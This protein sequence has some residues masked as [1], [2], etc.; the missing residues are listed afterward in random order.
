MLLFQEKSSRLKLIS[1][2]S[3]AASPKCSAHDTRTVI[4]S[5]SHK[6]DPRPKCLAS[7]KKSKTRRASKLVGKNK[8]TVLPVRGILKSQTKVLP[9]EKSTSCISQDV[10]KV[11]Q[12]NRQHGNKHVTFS[13]N[14]HVLG[15]KRN[16]NST[17]DSEFQSFYNLISDV[18]GAPEGNIHT[19]EKGESLTIHQMEEAEEE[20]EINVQP[21]TGMLSSTRCNAD[22]GPNIVMHH[23]SGEENLFSKSPALR[24][25]TMHREN[26]Q[27]FEGC[28][29]GK[30]HD[31]LYTCSVAP[32][33]LEDGMP[34]LTSPL[35]GH[36][37]DASSSYG[38]FLAS[39]YFTDFLKSYPQSPNS[40]ASIFN[41]SANCR[42]QFPSQISRENNN[43]RPLQYQWFPHLSPKELMR[44]ICSLPDWNSKMAI[45]GETS[46]SDDPIGLPLNSQGELIRLSSSVN[47]GFEQLRDT[48]T[49]LSPSIS[50]AMH[51]NVNMMV[52]QA[53]SRTWNGVPADQLRM[54]S[55]GDLGRKMENLPLPSRLDTMEQYYGTRRT[56]ILKTGFDPSPRALGSDMDLREMLYNRSRQDQLVQKHPGHPNHISLRFSQST[57]RLMGQEFKIGGNELQELESREVW[58][59]KQTTKEQHANTA[60]M[61]SCYRSL[62]HLP[63][64]TVHP[65]STKLS[66]TVFHLSEPEVNP[67]AG[68][69]SQMIVPES[70]MF[71]QFLQSQDNIVC[72]DGYGIGKS[73]MM[74]VSYPHFSLAGTPL[75]G[76]GKTICREPFLCGYK[77]PSAFQT[78]VPASLFQD[79][80]QKMKRSYIE[81]ENKPPHHSNLAFKYPFL[82]KEYGRHIQQPWTQNS[83]QVMRPWLLDSREK[84][85][86]IDYS[87]TYS[88]RASSYDEWC[89]SGVDQQIKHS[90]Y[91]NCEPFYTFPRATLQN[92]LASP[93]SVHF[94]PLPVPPSIL[95]NSGSENRYE[96]KFEN[97]IKSR[98]AVG[99]PNHGRTSEKRLA[100]ASD[101]A[102]RLTK[103]PKL[104][105]HE[106]LRFVVPA[107][108]TCTN[109]EKDSQCSREILD[110]ASA[111]DKAK[112]MECGENAAQ[113][114]DSKVWCGMALDKTPGAPRSGPVKLT[115][116]A[117]YVLKPY[118]KKEKINS[119]PSHS[120]IPFAETTTQADGVLASEESAKVYRF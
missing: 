22:D 35:F 27:S 34:K 23:V 29:R 120:S 7:I 95:L 6:K 16:T 97:C 93:S 109:F 98:I 44:T 17:L 81:L 107:L 114:N 119:K 58:M 94:P 99:I 62:D 100:S 19:I 104:G 72:H 57:M 15:S 112:T 75:S 51:N 79:T 33:T 86:V 54:C 38:P 91:P 74:P 20:N 26:L 73:N 12:C 1:S 14:N 2:V 10:G 30:R 66:D 45:S 110:S 108:K 5:S 25:V 53:Y 9:S 36:S 117:R 89:I 70:R 43:D 102:V 82:H 8:K 80:T 32:V 47:G 49:F 116:G 39:G 28:N 96:G 76:S 50:S 92:S 71:P 103:I 68:R 4:E 46:T 115:P 85:A 87:Q 67:A 42:R 59:D 105:N 3:L 52:D 56:N 84:G 106:D 113:K 64:F 111:Q 40:S 37:S 78:R 24:P 48:S 13:V 63:D 65:I 69:V 61:A 55:I 77:S 83:Y 118:Q 18:P 60:G 11:N 101:D 90:V 31:S 21:V 41:S 88:S